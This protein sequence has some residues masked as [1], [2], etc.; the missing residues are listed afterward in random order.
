MNYTLP[1]KSIYFVGGSTKIEYSSGQRT[2]EIREIQSRLIGDYPVIIKASR[3]ALSAVGKHFLIDSLLRSGD[4]LLTVFY[5]DDTGGRAFW[6]AASFSY[7]GDTSPQLILAMLSLSSEAWCQVFAHR[8][9]GEI[10]VPGDSSDSNAAIT[11]RLWDKNASYA[12]HFPAPRGGTLNGKCPSTYL[13]NFP[14]NRGKQNTPV[15]TS[16]RQ[17]K[18]PVPIANNPPVKRTPP[19]HPSSEHNPHDN[20][21]NRT[22][23][24]LVFLSCGLLV[25][26]IA[27]SLKLCSS[28]CGVDTHRLKMLDIQINELK[29]DIDVIKNENKDLSNKIQSLQDAQQKLEQEI[30]NMKEGNQDHSYWDAFKGLINGHGNDSQE[31]MGDRASD[32]LNSADAAQ[33]ENPNQRHHRGRR[34]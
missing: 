34:R 1:I 33:K 6:S 5:N 31:N 8:V 12:Y 24:I 4:R 27:V 11:A 18:H 23:K 25:L 19:H 20:A 17:G 7:A 16:D 14:L 2:D 28:S 15:S 3:A 21:M 29:F 13:E 32:S 22:F 26:L 9:S 10:I 30:K